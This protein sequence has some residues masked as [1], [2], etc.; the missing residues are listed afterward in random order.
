MNSLI[1]LICRPHCSTFISDSTSGS[2]T[3]EYINRNGDDHHMGLLWFV[4]LQY[5]NRQNTLT[6]LLI[7]CFKWLLTM[8]LNVYTICTEFVLLYIFI[9]KKRWNQGHTCSFVPFVKMYN[10][11]IRL[12]ST[13]ILL[14][15]SDFFCKDQ[16]LINSLRVWVHWTAS[17]FHLQLFKK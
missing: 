17:H 3:V 14:K 13:F 8:L 11:T 15:C 5:Q 7:Y 10:S 16:L 12:F 9:Q 2:I 6:C 4:S 1:C